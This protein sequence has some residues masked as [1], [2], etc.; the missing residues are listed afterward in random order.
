M[1]DK[2]RSKLKRIIS[3]LLAL[4]MTGALS[5]VM[6]AS[7]DNI[8]VSNDNYSILA[9]KV[10]LN[11]THVNVNGDIHGDD[12]LEFGGYQV[13]VNGGCYY[14]NEIKN[15]C[16]ELTYSTG[17]C[18]ENHMDIPQLGDCL[19]YLAGLTGANEYHDGI[20]FNWQ[21]E[22]ELSS[23]IS[24]DFFNAYGRNIWVQDIIAS[25]NDLSFNSTDL[26]THQYKEAFVY[27][28]NGDISIQAN[29]VDLDGLIYAP[30]GKVIINATSIDFSGVIIAE[31]VEINGN[32]VNIS[33][34]ESN[35]YLIELA[36]SIYGKREIIAV[37]DY[38][39]DNSLVKLAWNSN[40]IGDAFSVWASYD[41]T[42]YTKVTDINDLSYDYQV[43]NGHNSV[44][45]Y[46]EQELL[47]GTKLGSNVVSLIADENGNYSV[48]MDD[49]DKDGLVD[50]LEKI[51]GTNVNDPD[52][53]SDGLTDYEEA[54]F[55]HTDP[56]QYDSDQND[57]CDADEDPDRDGLNFR[58]ELDLGTDLF[59]ED[60]DNDHLNDGDE[61]KVHF[62]DPLVKDTDGDDFV[63]GY[64]VNYNRDPLNPDSDG[65]GISDGDDIYTITKSSKESDSKV[66][67]ELTIDIPGKS[68]DSLSIDK[69]P[70]DDVFLP[71]E[72]PGFIGNGFD[73]YV[74][75]EFDTATM[76]YTF[77][78]SLLDTPDFEP[79]VYYCDIV[80]QKMVLLDD[81]VYDPVTCTVTA[82]TTHFSRYILL[83][84]TA[85]EKIWDKDFAG[86]SVDN[87]GKTVA[88]DIALVIDSSGSMTW[89]DPKNL[90]KDAA[91]EFVDKLS[92]IDEAAIIDF[93]SSSK[94]NRNLTSNR[95]LL[96]SAIDDIDS[97]G[98]TSLTAGVSKGLE[99]LSKS[100]DKKIM[101]LLTD[102]KG[103]YDKSLTTQAINAGVTIYTIGLGTNNDIDQPLLNSIATETGGKY[104]HAKKDIDIQGS[105]DNVSGDLGNKDSDEDGLPDIVEKNLYWFNGV[106]LSKAAKEHKPSDI[107][108]YLGFD[109]N[110][111]NTFYKYLSDGDIV[112]E[113]KQISKDRYEA[114]LLDGV[115]WD[116][117][118]FNK[119]RVENF[120][121]DVCDQLG[122]MLASNNTD[123]AIYGD[124]VAHHILAYHSDAGVYKCEYCDYTVVDPK[125]ED[126]DLLSEADKYLMFSVDSM[127]DHAKSLG[128]RKMFQTTEF[129]IRAHTAKNYGVTAKNY[130]TFDNYGHYVAPEICTSSFN[131]MR[132]DNY[133]L[134][135]H[136]KEE[137]LSDTIN[138]IGEYYLFDH[139]GDL[140]DDAIKPILSTAIYDG[141]LYGQY[142]VLGEQFKVDYKSALP[143]ETVKEF[144]S[145]FLAELGT[146]FIDDQM[147][148]ERKTNY[149][150]K[151]LYKKM[152]EDIAV[153]AFA[154]YI[155]NGSYTLAIITYDVLN[156]ILNVTYKIG[157]RATVMP[158]NYTT[159]I[160]YIL[161]DGSSEGYP[162]N[163]Y[164][165]I[166][167]IA[168]IFGKKYLDKLN[169]VNNEDNSYFINNNITISPAHKLD[170]SGKFKIVVNVLE[171]KYNNYSYTL[172]DP[173]IY[174]FNNFTDL[175]M[176][177]TRNSN[178]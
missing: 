31:E 25:K 70:E 178:I 120:R 106:S 51:L 177:V 7:A 116:I 131:N 78:E 168:D 159:N 128:E 134:S 75:C 36:S 46:I 9:E 13:T 175:N 156:I 54:Y 88:M 26:S 103:P 135:I 65:D 101:I 12:S 96:Y 83:N 138:S 143:E 108:L 98:G 146:L 137:G 119:K 18:T 5:A 154:D 161:K 163:E 145:A 60:T 91:K 72:M 15:Y 73:F 165:F 89:N 141:F 38:D 17:V 64:E 56:I 130:S 112:V 107:D 117:P 77:D 40:M 11:G 152:I 166:A 126:E 58:E 10:K 115:I 147:K 32:D 121:E 59:E 92:S 174:R 86:T 114:K 30:N 122:N 142:T 133:Y 100:N 62:T 44:D 140:L 6:P 52:T 53:D 27:S 63:D 173:N 162:Y 47:S 132:L 23:T 153:T 160:V 164:Q 2:N 167:Q 85:F 123:S 118:N 151:Q 94:I 8:I 97:S 84:K 144:V 50:P 111:K 169:K 155:S 124:N 172:E 79:A 80:N 125:I 104:Y 34:S 41:G 48:V 109:H 4:T 61:V 57:I 102:G 148:N 20:V 3:G 95:T 170:H 110:N 19:Y 69:V 43:E 87:S 35:A 1:K 139:M 71:S 171:E 81:Q 105:F 33:T 28:A 67:V 37:G 16:G 42:D 29:N 113:Y 55:T 24:Y 158:G 66:S 90:R 127:A 149:E 76:K 82:K 176:I 45:I 49:S 136:L 22:L 14:T 99:A 157:G 39:S 21:E 74:D 68:V 93:D 150:C 129:A